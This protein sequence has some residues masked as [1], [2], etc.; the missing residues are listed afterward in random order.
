MNITCYLA[1]IDTKQALTLLLQPMPLLLLLY[2]ELLLSHYLQYS[3]HQH[4]VI[5]RNSSITGLTNLINAEAQQPTGYTNMKNEYN[6]EVKRK[7]RGSGDRVMI[8]K[9]SSAW[10]QYR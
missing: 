9:N 10:R 8:G 4:T 7:S 1:N 3:I 5:H 6:A 2:W